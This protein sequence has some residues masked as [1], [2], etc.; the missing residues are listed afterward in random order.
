MMIKLLTM[1]EEEPTEDE[2]KAI[3]KA[4]KAYENGETYSTLL[5]NYVR[6]NTRFNRKSLFITLIVAVMYTNVYNYIIPKC[7]SPPIPL[8]KNDF[9]KLAPTL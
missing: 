7:L 6:R 8:L 5:T 1:P 2:Y 9:C 4:R 3:E